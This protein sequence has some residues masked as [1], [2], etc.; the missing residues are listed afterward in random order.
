MVTVKYHDSKL[1]HN[2]ITRNSVTGALHMLSKTPVDWHSKK[3][4][5]VETTTCG[6][7]YL[8]ARTCADQFLDLRITCEFT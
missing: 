8:S 1:Y 2:V 6:S 5:E 4:P 7:E 3:R